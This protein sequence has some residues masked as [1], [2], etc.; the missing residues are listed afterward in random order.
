MREHIQKLA[1]FAAPTT[2]VAWIY[3]HMIPSHAMLQDLALIA[4]IFASI[5]AG[6]FHITQWWKSVRGKQPKD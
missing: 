6:L 5:A 2:W 1:D 3:T 4:A